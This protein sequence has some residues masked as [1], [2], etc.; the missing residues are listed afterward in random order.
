MVNSVLFG[1]HD[2]MNKPVVDRKFDKLMNTPEGQQA[3]EDALVGWEEGC[4]REPNEE[5]LE[6]IY[7]LLLNNLSTTHRILGNILICV[8]I[9]LFGLFIAQIY[10]TTIHPESVPTYYY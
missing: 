2:I 1:L 8:T 10:Y 7:T 6:Y 3:L 5:E 4:G 9:I